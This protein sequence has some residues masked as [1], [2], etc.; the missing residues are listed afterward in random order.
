MNDI[1]EITFCLENGDTIEEPLHHGPQGFLP[2]VQ[3]LIRPELKINYGLPPS[4]RPRRNPKN[5]GR[6]FL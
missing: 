6:P 5:S 3:F 4:S 1:Q 2:E